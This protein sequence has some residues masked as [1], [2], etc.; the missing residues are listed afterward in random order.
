VALLEACQV[1][2][3]TISSFCARGSE[4]SLSTRE[5]ESAD[6]LSHILG[7]RVKKSQKNFRFYSSQ[8]SWT[9]CV[10]HNNKK[11]K[12]TPKLTQ[13]NFPQSIKAM[14]V[15]EILRDSSNWM[16]PEQKPHLTDWYPPPFG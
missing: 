4:F 1:Y 5:R 12:F 3:E 16:Q 13:H 9:T 8:Y 7:L 10:Q 6:L 14:V 2:V 11:T 15:R